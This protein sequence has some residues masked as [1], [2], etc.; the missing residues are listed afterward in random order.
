MAEKQ[1]VEEPATPTTPKDAPEATKAR[2]VTIEFG[3][4]LRA[5]KMPDRRGTIDLTP[6]E[7]GMDREEYHLGPSDIV[8]FVYKPL[9]SG[10]MSEIRELVKDFEEPQ[11]SEEFDIEILLRCLEKPK[12]PDNADGRKALKRI[13]S[14]TRATIGLAIRNQSGMGLHSVKSAREELGKLF[15]LT[16]NSH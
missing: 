12:I 2:K 4:L 8:T 1:A 7:L 6:E 10:A 14:G 15:A 16:P 5:K 11:Y 9:E 13:L 3:D